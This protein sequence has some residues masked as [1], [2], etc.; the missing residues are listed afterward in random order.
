MYE[1]GVHRFIASAKQTEMSEFRQEGAVKLACSN[2]EHAVTASTF[3][4]LDTMLA[5]ECDLLPDLP[6]SSS[7]SSSKFPFPFQTG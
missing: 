7:I 1:A 4:I 5:V 2:K 6:P 3:T